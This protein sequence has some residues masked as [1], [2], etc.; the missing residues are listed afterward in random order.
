MT[1]PVAY[2]ITLNDYVSFQREA[3]WRAMPRFIAVMVVLVGIIALAG[4][5]LG[6]RGMIGGAVIGWI[7]VV[8]GVP[9]FARYIRIPSVAR[10][11]FREYALIRE[12]M[13]LNL[14]DE[15]FSIA[16]ASGHV[17]MAWSNVIL[18][19]EN[20]CMLA[21]HPNQQMGY[22]LPKDAIGPERV[23]YIREQLV[24]SGLPSK[25]KRRK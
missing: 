19:S 22:I 5:A 20:D 25:G 18:W 8:I 13:T 6:E 3:A 9:L 7:I 1:D 21:I 15:G 16:Q 10:K 14:T 24:E 11:T 2:H 12:E 17:A 23:G 4:I